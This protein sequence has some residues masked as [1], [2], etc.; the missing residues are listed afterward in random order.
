MFS[1]RLTRAAT[2][3]RDL[4][5][6]SFDGVVTCDRYAAYE[7]Y[8][9]QLCWAHLK[10]DFQA[11]IDAGGSSKRIGSRLMDVAHELFRHW[12]RYRDGTITRRTMVRNIHRLKY[13]VWAALEDG[14][15]C[16]RAS[17]AATCSHLFERFDH[18]WTFLSHAEVEPTNNAAERAL[19]HAVIW[20][21][22]SFGTQSASGSRFMETLLSVIETCRQQKRDVLSFVTRAVE[23]HFAHQPCPSLLPHP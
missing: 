2:V 19:R 23:A 15:R 18:L 8:R 11:M 12:Q 16:G 5:G 3:V 20:R 21:K 14:M 4:L 9:R 22:L 7:G 13:R 1:V 6:E 17:T 10:R